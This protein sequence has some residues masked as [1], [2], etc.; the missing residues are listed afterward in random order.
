MHL[1]FAK[2]QFLPCLQF[3]VK[4]MQ[5]CPTQ[6]INILFDQNTT[7]ELKLLSRLSLLICERSSVLAEFILGTKYSSETGNSSA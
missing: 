3:C 1:V 4:G 2:I 6:E 7:A 5:I